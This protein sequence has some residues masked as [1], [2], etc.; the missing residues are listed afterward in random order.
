LFYVIVLNIPDT[1][2]CQGSDV[3]ESPKAAINMVYGAFQ[4]V[5][6]EDGRVCIGTTYRHVQQAMKL[7]FEGRVNP[8]ISFGQVKSQEILTI[9]NILGQESEYS[10]G[11]RDT[12]YIFTA[13]NWGRE[14][15]TWL[16]F[17]RLFES[18]YVGGID[19]GDTTQRVCSVA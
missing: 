19:D 16:K 10:C 7:Q 12:P 3:V 2:W 9:E 17:R 6:D 11:D 5:A 18:G 13:A 1:G 4:E 8:S 15:D 14:L